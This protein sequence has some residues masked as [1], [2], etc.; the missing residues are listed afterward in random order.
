M[1]KLEDIQSVNDAEVELISRQSALL[2]QKR[3]DGFYGELK[4]SGAIVENYIKGVLKKHISDGYRI[5]S[6]YIATTD[7]ILNTENLIQHD[8]IIVDGRIPSIYD[9]GV[10]DIEIVAAESVCGIIEVKRTLTKNSVISAVNQ[11]KNTKDLLENYDN[12]VKS[13]TRAANNAAGPT[14]SMGTRSPFYAI[15]G[16]DCEKNSVTQEFIKAELAP[17]VCEFIDMV[18][19]PSK[20][21]LLRFAIKSTTDG[22]IRIPSIVSRSQKGY[23][24][25][26]VSHYFMQENAGSIYRMA[27]AM[28]RT[29][30]NNTS[31]SR[32]DN[33]K[34]FKY[35]G[36]FGG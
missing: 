6:G 14:L 29:W 21:F 34:D 24:P 30:I 2:L 11:L 17:I 25:H 16:L 26:F 4:S 23:K 33:G 12:G 1:K 7:T 3:S 28:Y 27:V 9:F 36:V 32:M 5:C 31:G 18:W 35:F 22:K 19:V 10:S 20:A 8:I 15:M 13:K